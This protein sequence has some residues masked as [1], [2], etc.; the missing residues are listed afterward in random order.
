MSIKTNF[1]F[2]RGLD[3]D[4]LQTQGK[5][6]SQDLSKNFKSIVKQL[7]QS[8][9]PSFSILDLGGTSFSG[10]FS[11]GGGVGSTDYTFTHN[12]NKIP[13]GFILLDSTSN[14]FGAGASLSII[15]LS[16]TV[17]QITVRL[18]IDSGVAAATSGTFKILVLE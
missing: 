14:N 8:A 11:Y 10:S 12:F 17:T 6:L 18:S 3:A 7:K 15:R 1:E 16:W 9:N 4:E 13:N 5:R 2:P